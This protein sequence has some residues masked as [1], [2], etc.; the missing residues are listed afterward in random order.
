MSEFSISFD[1]N[2]LRKIK[3]IYK[4]DKS[5]YKRYRTFLIKFS[6]NP[7]YPGLNTH[8]VTVSGYGRVYSSTITGDI[9]VIWNLEENYVLLLLD[10]GGHEGSTKV[11]R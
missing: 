11:Y 3:K 6:E 9:R 2:F 5:L 10:I 1:K 8:K 4:R 7:F